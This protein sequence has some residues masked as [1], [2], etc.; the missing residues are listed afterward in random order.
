MVDCCFIGS[1]NALNYLDRQSLAVVISQVQKDIPLSDLDYSRLQSF[2]LWL[3]LMYA[4][5]GVLVDRAGAG[6]I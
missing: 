6:D 1:R 5:G 3:R 4:G 2:F